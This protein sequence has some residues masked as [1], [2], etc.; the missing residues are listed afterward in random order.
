M[1]FHPNRLAGS[2]VIEPEER[3]AENL[4]R[5]HERVRALQVGRAGVKGR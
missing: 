3:A 2:Y 1:L 5:L 4:E